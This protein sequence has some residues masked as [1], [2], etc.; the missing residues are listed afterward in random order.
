MNI[1]NELANMLQEE[2]GKALKAT[3]I[4]YDKTNKCFHIGDGIFVERKVWKNFLKEQ[5]KNP[6]L[7]GKEFQ[8][9]EFSKAYEEFLKRKEEG[10]LEIE[11]VKYVGPNEKH[12]RDM[13]FG[14][15]ME[16]L[17]EKDFES[18][19]FKAIEKPFDSWKQ[20]YEEYASGETIHE[21]WMGGIHEFT[22]IW[23]DQEKYPFASVCV[24][25][26]YEDG[27]YFSIRQ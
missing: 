26:D 23:K 4:G 18:T 10:T 3:P 12:A 17:R 27:Y 8:L 11:T 5:K 14:E 1:E 2:I 21:Q 24:K 22:F 6:E 15:I 19:R 9:A 16:L 20:F 25:Q 7:T 13:N